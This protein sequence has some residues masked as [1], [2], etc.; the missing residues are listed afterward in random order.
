MVALFAFF[1]E[2]FHSTSSTVRS[3]TLF[4]NCFGKFFCSW[5]Y[6]G[7]YCL[8]TIC[9]FP[10]S[11]RCGF[12]LLNCQRYLHHVFGRRCSH[13]NPFLC[14]GNPPRFLKFFP[15][16]PDVPAVTILDLVIDPATIRKISK[17]DSLKIIQFTCGSAVQQN[18]GVSRPGVWISFHFPLFFFRA[19]TCSVNFSMAQSHLFHSISPLALKAAS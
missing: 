12:A 9:I 6:I 5:F 1:S 19:I 17:T 10:L 11:F 14:Y 7:N 13:K 15:C 16:R 2:C 4:S 3:F 8:P 18:W